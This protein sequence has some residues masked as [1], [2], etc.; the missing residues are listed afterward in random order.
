MIE[1]AKDVEVQVKA[2]RRTFTSEYKRAILREAEGCT[3]RGEIGALL[4]R[5]GLYSSHLLDWR[6]ALE[7]SD[8][9][10][11][12]PKKRGPVAKPVDPRD[13]KLLEQEREIA[14]LNKRIARAE[15][16]IDLQKK[17]SEILGI[18]LP[19]TEGKL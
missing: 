4:R 15:A 12:E 2:R 11:L 14:R 9:K 1:A 10:A 13:R 6:L 16:I 18:D 17:V 5:E 7:K 19:D 8:L 3:K